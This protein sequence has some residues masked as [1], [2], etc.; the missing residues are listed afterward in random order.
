MLRGNRSANELV[1]YRNR[2]YLGKIGVGVYRPIRFRYDNLVVT[3]RE[4]LVSQ[5]KR[6]AV[7]H[8][9]AALDS[10]PVLTV[11]RHRTSDAVMHLT[12]GTNYD[13]VRRRLVNRN[14]E[15][16]QMELKST[17]FNIP[18][19]SLSGLIWLDCNGHDAKQVTPVARF[20]LRDTTTIKL[21]S[22]TLTE[23]HLVDQHPPLSYCRISVNDIPMVL[24]RIA[25][26]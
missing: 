2:H 26:N 8:T 10:T 6:P 16:A 1:V 19:E 23:H 24:S 25:R 7:S 13:L 14:A 21:L 11:P 22:P 18:R 5:T 12:I 15:S 3:I 20:V 4:F 17:T 9:T